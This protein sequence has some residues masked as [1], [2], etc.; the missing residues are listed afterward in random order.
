MSSAF[1]SFT[2]LEPRTRHDRDAPRRSLLN[3]IWHAL[4]TAGQRRAATEIARQVRLHGGQPTGRPELDARQL[5]AL[6]GVG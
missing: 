3:R 4:L 6:R 5:A 1:P 2:Q